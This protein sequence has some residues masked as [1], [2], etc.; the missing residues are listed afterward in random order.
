[1]ALAV[2]CAYSGITADEVSGLWQCSPNHCAPRITELKAA[3]ELVETN[4]TRLTRAGSPARVL[5]AKQFAIEPDRLEKA[6]EWL[7]VARG[8]S[9]SL[10]PDLAPDRTYRE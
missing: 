9:A 1:M 6:R 4:R 2:Q 5:V 10:F 8:E 7:R 3:G